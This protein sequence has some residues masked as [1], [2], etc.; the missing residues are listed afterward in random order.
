MRD[1]PAIFEDWQVGHS[2]RFSY[3][4]TQII[5]V[6][7]SVLFCLLNFAEGVHIQSGLM[8]FTWLFGILAILLVEG[9]VDQLTRS[10]TDRLLVIV[11]LVGVTYITTPQT[12]SVTALDH[13][14]AMILVFKIIL[15]PISSSTI[16]LSSNVLV[17]KSEKVRMQLVDQMKRLENTEYAIETN[18]EFS[19]TVN[20][21]RISILQVFLV[22]LVLIILLEFFYLSDTQLGLDSIRVIVNV[23]VI[24]CSISLSSI[25]FRWYMQKRDIRTSKPTGEEEEELP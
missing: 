8:I 16:T 20:R 9:L 23:I 10:I 17:P 11:S 5:D 4:N 2:P 15:L 13:I 22:P 7:L 12:L 24:L 21:T 25:L 3:Q 19:S 14:E 6:S 1:D 18:E